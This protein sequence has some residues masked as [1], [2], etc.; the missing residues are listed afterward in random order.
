MELGLEARIWKLYGSKVLGRW[1]GVP[2]GLNSTFVE[3]VRLLPQRTEWFF[4]HGVDRQT[5]Y[6]VRPI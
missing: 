3:G 5:L 4:P 6:E 2:L 1:G